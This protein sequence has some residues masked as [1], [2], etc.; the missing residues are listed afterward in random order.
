VGALITLM[1]FSVI[2]QLYVVARV[3]NLFWLYSSLVRLRF[4][5]PDTPRPY[6]IPGGIPVLV[7]LGIPTALIAGVALYYSKVRKTFFA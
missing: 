4:T 6:K 1:E 7:A 3:V 2:V 5:E